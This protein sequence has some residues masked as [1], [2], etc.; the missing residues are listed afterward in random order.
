MKL[1]LRFIT[2]LFVCLIFIG[3]QA[4]FL[5]ADSKTVQIP[6]AK[7]EKQSDENAKFTSLIDEAKE[8]MFWDTRNFPGIDKDRPKI[9]SY[10]P[11]INAI[12]LLLQKLAEVDYK[13]LTRSNYVDFMLL[14][15]NLY[16]AVDENEKLNSHETDPR[17]YIQAI[18]GIQFDYNSKIDRRRIF[19]SLGAL[20]TLERYY[21][22]AR[23]YLT[24]PYDQYLFES[25]AIMRNF[26]IF[27]NTSLTLA[28]MDNL[29][30]VSNQSWINILYKSI[31][32]AESFLEFL[33]SLKS[34]TL[35]LTDEL[36]L[37]HENVKIENKLKYQHLIPESPAEL[38]KFAKD[39]FNK[40]DAEMKQIAIE[41]NQNRKDFDG[42]SN[43]WHAI[44]EEMKN[45]HPAES[46]IM[47]LTQEYFKN[48]KKAIAESGVFPL[49]PRIFDI[50]VQ[51]YVEKKDQRDVPYAF[52]QGLGRKPDQHGKYMLA[53]PG[54]DT[55]QDE[56]EQKLRD[57]YKERLKIITVHECFPGH[58]LQISW[59]QNI[60]R[61]FL[62]SRLGYS[63]V[64]VEGWGLYSEQIMGELGFY[65]GLCGKLAMLKM[66]LW[67]CARVIIDISRHFFGMT[68]EEAVKLLTDEILLEKVNAQAEVRRYF[69][70]PTQPLSYLYGWREI[71]RLRDRMILN[72]VMTGE[73]FSLYD[74]HKAFLDSPYMPVYLLWATM[75][76]EYRAPLFDLNKFKV[77]KTVPMEKLTQK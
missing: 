42:K 40:I 49:S 75:Y 38:L 21:E 45:N 44:I 4:S 12:K 76:G 61:S 1:N 32:E 33:L 27:L 58:H 46:E 48:A 66:R 7:V 37:K 31:K 34:K 67:R 10:P 41:I 29:E 3:S 39:E 19:W 60:Q 54:E 53:L 56:R 30:Y 64:Y 69:N 36:R 55:P 70:S 74:F 9:I 5:H 77:Q 47:D 13:Q 52:Y 16:S 73:E 18:G 43:D 35:K 57:L 2:L 65:D 59:G 72:T 63:T 68:E 62:Q 25:I 17:I 22:A 11:T 50:Q 24:A 51:K 26:K 15:H 28:I 14:T 20:P 71:N 6:E 8:I 23:K